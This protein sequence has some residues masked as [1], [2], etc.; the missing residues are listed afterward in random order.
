MITDI[1]DTVGI[2]E[3]INLWLDDPENSSNIMYR[4]KI[5]EK[6][7]EFGEMPSGLGDNIRKALSERGI[8]DL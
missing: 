4:K 2:D 8:E 1:S 5:P 7:A 3:L 6:I